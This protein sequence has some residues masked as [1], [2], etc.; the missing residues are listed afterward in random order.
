[1]QREAAYGDVADAGRTRAAAGN[2]RRLFFAPEIGRTHFRFREKWAT[3]WINPVKHGWVARVQ[4]W[5]YSSFH[6]YMA[7]GVDA[8]DWAGAGIDDLPVGE[9]DG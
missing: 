1:M 2:N 5:P 7:I 4:N 3:L 6:R 8:S 9:R